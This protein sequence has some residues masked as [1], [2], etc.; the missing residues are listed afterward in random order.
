M[1]I[2]I[3]TLIPPSTVPENGKASFLN[4]N[5]FTQFSS[6]GL[7]LAEAVPQPAL[8]DAY[9]SI[10]KYYV[11]EHIML[12][13]VPSRIQF[14]VNA[15]PTAVNQDVF[16]APTIM[17]TLPTSGSLAAFTPVN[18]PLSIVDRCS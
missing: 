8:F 4:A 16:Q 9:A 2:S 3:P 15:G 10:Y 12:K 14:D 13:W 11:P 18:T 5:G 17:G 7:L 1:R 6:S